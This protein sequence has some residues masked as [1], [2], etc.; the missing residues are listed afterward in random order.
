MWDVVKQYPWKFNCFHAGWVLW[1]LLLRAS[2]S[3]E[4]EVGACT[5]AERRHAKA[6]HVLLLGN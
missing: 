4:R 3:S 2:H 5:A 1:A 6:A